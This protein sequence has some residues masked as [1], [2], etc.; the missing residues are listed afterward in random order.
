MGIPVN[1]YERYTVNERGRIYSLISNRYLKPH[2]EN[3][4]YCSVELFGKNGKS[5]RLLIH[6]LV[7][8]A[9]IPNPNNYTEINHKDENP[10]NNHVD[11]LEW[12]DH[13]YNMNFGTLQERKRKSLTEFYKSERIK[14]TARKNGAKRSKAVLQFTKN[15]DF[16]A[17][18]NSGVE[19]S[20]ATGADHSH[21]LEC[22]NVKRYKTVGGFIWKFE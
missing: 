18:Y 17:R 5:K 8:A 11:N 3:T 13:K 12:C 14:E 9:F 2:I 15:G 6:R 4:G 22:C 21:I 10:L 16:I 7:A 20:K 19:A 1:G